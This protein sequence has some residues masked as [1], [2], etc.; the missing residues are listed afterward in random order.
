MG[1]FL[2]LPE[3]EVEIL[4][5]F[6][7][8]LVRV[9]ES[10]LTCCIQLVYTQREL[11][12]KYGRSDSNGEGGRVSSQKKKK[13][14]CLTAAVQSGLLRL[15]SEQKLVRLPRL[16]WMCPWMTAAR[17]CELTAPD[18]SFAPLILRLMLN[19]DVKFMFYI[20]EKV[21]KQ[22]ILST[23]QSY[24]WIISSNWKIGGT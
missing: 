9:L 8:L 2:P 5:L 20:D 24:Q 22:R 1:L 14:T 6:P 11:K 19:L 12:R 10:P 7:D 18:R 13:K 23:K 16:W 21:I 15:L 4:Y 17:Q 3:A